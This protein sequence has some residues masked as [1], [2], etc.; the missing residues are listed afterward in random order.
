VHEEEN[1]KVITKHFEGILGNSES[2]SIILDFPR[3]AV[4]TMDLSLLDGCFSE[5][6]IG[7]NKI[8]TI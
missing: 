4:P 5:E 8:I 3:L 6:E 1:A 7:N 2:D